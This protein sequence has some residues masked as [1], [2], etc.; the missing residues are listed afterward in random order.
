MAKKTIER[1]TIGY[2]HLMEDGSIRKVE[3]DSTNKLYIKGTDTPLLPKQITKT[4]NL[5]AIGD[6]KF[7]FIR[8]VYPERFQ[9]YEDAWH[10]SNMDGSFAYNGCTDDF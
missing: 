5:V 3:K 8:N 9:S 7:K 10:E 4:A 6:N 1:K 2:R